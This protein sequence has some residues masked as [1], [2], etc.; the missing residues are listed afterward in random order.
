MEG[1]V[2]FHRGETIHLSFT[3]YHCS[4][5]ESL[6]QNVLKCIIRFLILLQNCVFFFSSFHVLGT[7]GTLESRSEECHAR[8]Q[9]A[10]EHG[11]HVLHSTSCLGQWAFFFPS[12]VYT[13]NVIN[14]EITAQELHLIEFGSPYCA[15]FV[16]CQSFLTLELLTLSDL[17]SVLKRLQG[18]QLH[19][20]ATSAW[21]PIRTRLWFEAEIPVFWQSAPLY[22]QVWCSFIVSSELQLGDTWAAADRMWPLALLYPI[23]SWLQ[24]LPRCLLLAF[25]RRLCFLCFPLAVSWFSLSFGAS[26]TIVCFSWDGFQRWGLCRHSG[27]PQEIVIRGPRI[28]SFTHHP[29]ECPKFLFSFFLL[30]HFF[31]NNSGVC[32]QF[33]MSLSGMIKLSKYFLTF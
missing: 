23:S 26:L 33:Q 28:I 20:R 17:S 19:N 14:W 7:F 11:T 6:W 8:S 29:S 12:A 18:E 4:Y 24:E 21:K 9:S 1:C 25:Y 22:F 13:N 3:C 16:Q 27:L 2:G 10:G 5:N 30:L 31:F 15:D 32:Q